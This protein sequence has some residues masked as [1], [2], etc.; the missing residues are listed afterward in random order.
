MLGPSE[1]DRMDLEGLQGWG[2]G[3]GAF[4]GCGGGVDLVG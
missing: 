3:A 1:E 2:E 4:G